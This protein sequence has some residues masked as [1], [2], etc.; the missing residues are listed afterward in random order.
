MWVVAESE[1]MP[2]YSLATLQGL[3]YDSLDNNTGL[4]PVLQVTDALNNAVRKTNFLTGIIEAT[5]PA[6]T[7]AG[8]L[9]YSTPTGIL[10]PMRIYCEGVELGKYSMRELGAQFRTWAT[11]TTTALGPVARWCPI[12]IGSFVLH[13]VDAAGGKLLEV[14]GVAPITPMVNS[15][16]TV[17]LDDE[18]VPI[19]V[20]YCRARLL[21]K[22]GGKPFASASAAYQRF[23]RGLKDA[24]IWEGMVFPRYWIESEEEPTE[25]K[26]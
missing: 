7:Q 9:V 18:F 8:Q 3:V 11:D 15:G 4:Y 5:I 1:L 22:L 12:G 6:I 13:P 17:D 16:D 21:L 26:A 19:L 2:S 23:M 24:V 25:G 10:V 20:D 14:N